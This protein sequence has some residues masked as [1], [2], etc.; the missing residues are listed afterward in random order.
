[1]TNLFDIAVT[2]FMGFDLTLLVL[3]RTTNLNHN[4]L[5]K[6][7]VALTIGVGLF[8]LLQLVS[9]KIIQWTNLCLIAAI[10]TEFIMLLRNAFKPK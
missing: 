6:F 8:G 4:F 2:A 7:C 1:M 5:I 10:G 3:D 9:A